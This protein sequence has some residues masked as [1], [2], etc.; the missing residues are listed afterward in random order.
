MVPSSDQRAALD[1]SKTPIG[2]MQQQQSDKEIT[3]SFK[4][5]TDIDVSCDLHKRM[6]DREIEGHK[7]IE[8]PFT[9]MQ[10]A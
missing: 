3:P 6:S 1:R 5:K 10:Q 7:A 2:F 9:K 8:E 4:S